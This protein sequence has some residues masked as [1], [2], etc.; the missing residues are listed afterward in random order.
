MKKKKNFDNKKKKKIIH[1]ENLDKKIL[2]LNST[3][4][5]FSM[6]YFYFHS[7]SLTILDKKF[8]PNF[9]I[10]NTILYLLLTIPIPILFSTDCSY[11]Y[12][13]VSIK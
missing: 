3:F 12:S 13:I 9:F 6:F 5:L 11:S 7:Y 4:F 1:N 2:I 10:L 8:A